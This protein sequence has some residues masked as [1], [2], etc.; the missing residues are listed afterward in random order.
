MRR[1]HSDRLE[2]WNCFYAGYHRAATIMASAAVQR[3]LRELGATGGNLKEQIADL[4]ERRVITEIM[5]RVADEARLSGNDA[6]HPDTLGEVDAQEAQQ[7]LAFMDAFLESTLVLPNQ[8][9]ARAAERAALKG[10]PDPG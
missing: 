4:V 8:L 6:A 7:S 5:G 2:A 1:P 9:D 10:E 3:A